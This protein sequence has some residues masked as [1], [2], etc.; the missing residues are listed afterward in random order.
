MASCGEKQGGGGCG[1]KRLNPMGVQ[2]TRE[3][4]EK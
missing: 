3:N 1:C 2:G 4:E